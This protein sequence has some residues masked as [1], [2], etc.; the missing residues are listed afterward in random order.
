MNQEKIKVSN[1][2]SA[3]LALYVEANKHLS[4]LMFMWL[5]IFDL[6]WDSGTTQNHNA[7]K[8]FVDN[9]NILRV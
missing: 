3:A 5:L 9:Y 6:T 1:S 7:K 4:T 8:K 2:Q